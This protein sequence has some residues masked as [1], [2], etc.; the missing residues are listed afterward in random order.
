MEKLKSFAKIHIIGNTAFIKDLLLHFLYFVMSFLFGGIFFAGGLS[1]FGTGLV[2]AVRMRYLLSS[3]VGAAIGYSVFFGLSGSLRFVG[4]VCF[5]V[6]VRLGFSGRIPKNRRMLFCTVLTFFSSFISSVAVFAVAG[7]DNTFPVMYLCESA[8]ASA[9]SMFT[10]KVSEIAALKRKGAFFAPSD[11]ASVVFF[12]CVFLLSLARFSLFG[13][14]PARCLAYFLI[15]LFALCG[16]EAASCIAGVCCALTLGISETHPHLMLCFILTGLMTGLTGIYGKLPVAVS[17]IFCQVLSL[18]ISGDSATAVMSVAEAVVSGIIF[19]LVP[20]SLLFTAARAVTPMSRDAYSEERGRNLRFMLIRRSKA[21]KDITHSI[22]AVS[23]LLRKSLKPSPDM[24]Y[25]AVK[26][27]VCEK[28]T[29]CG[30][31][32]S[33][34]RELTEKAFREANS[35]LVRQGHIIPEELPERI[36][37][38]CRL[39]DKIAESFNCS[40][41]RYDASLVSR[42]EIAEAKRAAIMQFSCLASLLDEAAGEVLKAP[43]SDPVLAAALMPFFTEKGFSVLGINVFSTENERS[44]LQVY[45]SAVPVITDMP[46]LLDEIYELT[47]ICYDAPVTDEYSENGS[48]LSFSEQRKFRVEYHTASHT[49]AGESF[50][51]DTSECFYDG[52]GKFYAVLSDGMGTGSAAAIDSVMT[53]SIMSRLMRAGF[54]VDSAFETVNCSLLVRG[55]EETLSTLDIFTLDLDTAD[56]AFCKA[57]AAVSVIYKDNRTVIM[58]KSSLPL[59]ILK[60]ADFKKSELKLSDGDMVFLMSDGASVIPN[61]TFKEL[62]NKNCRSDARTLSEMIVNTALEFSPSGKHDDITVICVKINK[63]R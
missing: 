31:C 18:I 43:E 41:Y 22:N 33:K 25:E 47:G 44:V 28:C 11:T 17:L 27:E 21:L 5:I 23:N 36:S 2:G 15:M 29:K 32:W 14:S 38:V 19:F 16:K 60:E 9:F 34:C 45:C 63:Y 7:Q 54:T 4:A 56:A 6:L 57:G 35:V 62:I 52:T 1:P 40:L 51:G 55:P 8:I 49:G 53:C 58:E 20:R 46:S 59:G 61:L 48:V 13:F 3:A 26:D 39:P 42:N 37:L 30:F 50:S 10:L 24:L 12:G